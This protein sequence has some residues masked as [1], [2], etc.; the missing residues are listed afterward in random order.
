MVEERGE[1]MGSKLPMVVKFKQTPYKE[2]VWY[3]AI[4][5][6]VVYQMAFSHN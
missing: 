2:T 1:E 3:I 4:G 5:G 6:E